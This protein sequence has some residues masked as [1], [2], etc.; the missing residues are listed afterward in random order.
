VEFKTADD[1]FSFHAIQAK[2]YVEVPISSFS[3]VEAHSKGGV[4][5]FLSK[6]MERRSS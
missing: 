3:G 2:T 1:G 5:P 4:F 6:G